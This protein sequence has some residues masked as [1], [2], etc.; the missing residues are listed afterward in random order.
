MEAKKLDIWMIILAV[1]MYCM[2]NF[3]GVLSKQYYLENQIM[4]SLLFAVMILSYFSG[5]VAAMGTSA[6][7]IFFYGSYVLYRNIVLGYGVEF[8]VYYWLAILPVTAVVSSVTGS[9]IHRLQEENI[10]RQREFADLV[11]VDENTGLDNVRVFYGVLNQYMG[12]SKRYKLPLSLML[13]KL[14]YYEE[15]KGILGEDRMKEILKSIGQQLVK[16]TRVEDCSYI[17][18]DGR[19]FA[20]LL[21]SDEAGTEIVKKRIKE[22]ISQFNTDNAGKAI[23]IRIELKVGT[24][25][26]GEEILDALE[27]RKL[28][29]KDMEYDV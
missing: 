7:V 24:A 5:T 12:L 29:E 2:V 11:T 3:F 4:L 21:F 23:S 25:K 9:K 18:E 10:R 14:L 15:I 1:L 13:V 6:I 20:L 27:L 8:H 16:C 28:A 19:T 17:L 22:S 26:Y